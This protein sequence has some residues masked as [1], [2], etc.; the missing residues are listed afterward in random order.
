[1]TPDEVEAGADFELNIGDARRCNV[2]VVRMKQDDPSRN[3]HR[4]L[5]V[6]MVPA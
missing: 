2:A 5:R 3:W 1:M 4:M 6:G